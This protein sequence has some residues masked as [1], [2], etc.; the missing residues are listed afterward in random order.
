MVN[1]IIGGGEIGTSLYKALNVDDKSLIVVD[2]EETRRNGVL[3]IDE[4]HLD[5]KLNGKE[6][7][8][9]MHISFP[10]FEGFV[11]E[12]KRYQAKYK[13]NYTVIHSTVPIGTSRK[14]GAVHSPVVGLH[15]FLEE[16][17]HTF[18]K[19]LGGSD[20]SEVANYF[21]RAN[22]KVYLCDTQEDTELLKIQSTTFYAT[23]IEFNK[24]MKELCDKQKTPFSLWTLW[25]DNYNK[26]YQKLGYEEYSRPKLVPIMKKQGGHC[27][28]SNLK[29]IES[30]FSNFIDSIKES[31]K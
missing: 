17:L 6:L 22:I 18:T 7:V 20:A 21:R 13:P 10:Y 25:T 8:D 30:K 9:L 15:P 2:M 1:L 23:C 31:F 5:D 12:V 11:E 27:T 3:V 28:L 24:E 29:L 16:S 4:P 19:F 26:G 14:C